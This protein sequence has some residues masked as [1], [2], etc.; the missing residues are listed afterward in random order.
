[1][2]LR[3]ESRCSWQS[4]RRLPGGGVQRPPQSLRGGVGG[5][6]TLISIVVGSTILVQLQ[7]SP[8][9]GHPNIHF[10][11]FQRHSGI[12]GAMTRWLL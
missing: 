9:S 6:G 10:Q 3:E 11:D 8:H 5:G 4:D 12:L 2:P 7:C 1:M